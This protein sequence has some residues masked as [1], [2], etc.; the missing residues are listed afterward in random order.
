MTSENRILKSMD[1]PGRVLVWD[2]DE[3]LVISAPL[4]LGICVGSLLVT[5]SGLLLKPFYSRLRK[6]LPRGAL[7]AYIYWKLPSSSLRRRGMISNL[8]DSNAR[9]LLL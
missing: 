9:D 1:N 7:S 3:F 5:L 2:L 8:P 4:F 6:K